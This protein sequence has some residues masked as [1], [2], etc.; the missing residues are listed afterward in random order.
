[1]IDRV[2]SSQIKQILSEAA[3]AIDR[4]QADTGPAADAMLQTD[5]ASLIKQATAMTDADTAVVEK[6]AQL[7]A[8]RE[9]ESFENIRH[10]AENLI[11]FGI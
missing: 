8:D 4:Q 6:T 3:G 5:F 1:M 9:I 7:L 10:A 2:D 11:D